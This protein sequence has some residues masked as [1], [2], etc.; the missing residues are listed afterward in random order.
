MRIEGSAAQQG[1]VAQHGGSISRRTTGRPHIE[2]PHES[3]RRGKGAAIARPA[4]GTPD[5]LVLFRSAGTAV[6]RY[7]P[8][9]H[10]VPQRGNL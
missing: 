6:P 3:E 10:P 7:G 9:G 4:G 5:S 2:Q 1:T 8:V